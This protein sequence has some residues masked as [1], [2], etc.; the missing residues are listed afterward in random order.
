MLNI[1]NNNPFTI[2]GL[3]TVPKSNKQDK[4]IDALAIEE[5]KLFIKEFK[6]YCQKLQILKM[7]YFFLMII[8]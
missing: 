3:L 4:K 8:K 2:K 5:Q 6:K 1:V 7:S